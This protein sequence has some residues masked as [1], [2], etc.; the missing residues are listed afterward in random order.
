[1]RRS[2]KFARKIAQTNTTLSV[3]EESCLTVLM[4]AAFFVQH[5][6]IMKKGGDREARKAKCL[7]IS[8]EEEN[9]MSSI[10]KQI[11]GV[12]VLVA[13]LAFFG[14]AHTVSTDVNELQG[15]L[16]QKDKEIEGLVSANVDKDKTIGEYKTKFNEQS[17]ALSAAERRAEKVMET[18][19]AIEAPLLP[20]EAK[21][22]DC[23]ARVFVPPTYRTISEQRL[24]RGASEKVEVIP[25]KY[26]WVEEQV[27][28]KG[29]S[30]RLETI[31]AQYEWV[32]EQILVK[33]ASSR[34][35]EVPAKYDWVEEQVLVEEAHTTW[36]KGR[37]L[38]EKIDNTTGEIMCLVEIPA[39][40]KTV[41]Q[42]VMVTPPTTRKIEIPAKYEA[43]KKKIMV[44]PPTTRKI[45]IPADYKIVKVNKMVSPPQERRIP[46]SAEYQTVTRTE[47][48]SEG[49][50]EWRRVLCETNVSRDMIARVQTALRSAGHD[51]VFIDG[52]FGAKTH[53]AMKAY[54]QEKGLG[55]GSLTYK[56]LESLGIRLAR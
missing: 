23:Y 13:T 53:A 54:Q 25:A 32:E 56:T 46:I 31:P 17:K 24:K 18:S 45:E 44:K 21:P 4:G 26:E 28:V 29:A 11:L 52:V 41:K 48:V 22:G 8:R 2:A 37:G 6:I 55:V 19:R 42:K 40:Y 34:L 5:Q 49:R 39:A 20:P 33:G 3:F 7:L 15:Q 35:E 16:K 1:M 47:Q 10:R 50:L 51:P 14:C 12:T 38:I 36:K 30:E 9:T 43:V 27:L